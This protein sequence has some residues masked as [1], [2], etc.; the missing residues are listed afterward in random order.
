MTTPGD[1]ELRRRL[2]AQWEEAVED[3]IGHDQAVRT[4]FLDD[5]VLRALGEV[6]GRRV[7]DIGCGE[8]R[9]CRV[10]AGLGAEVTG[11]V[12][13]PVRIPSEGRLENWFGSLAEYNS[14]L[15]RPG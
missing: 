11:L 6:A 14:P 8:G 10:L 1:R 12:Y 3:W 2:Q 4:D 15:L 7:V 5:W 13:L 9:F